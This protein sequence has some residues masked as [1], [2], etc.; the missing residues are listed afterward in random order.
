MANFK[1]FSAATG[2]NSLSSATVNVAGDAVGDVADDSAPAVVDEG[3]LLPLSLSDPE[4]D[5]FGWGLELE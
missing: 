3:A 4:P 1:P 5:P 2:A